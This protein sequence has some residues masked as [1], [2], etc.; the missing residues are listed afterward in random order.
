MIFQVPASV[1]GLPLRGTHVYS[2]Q[3]VP[4]FAPEA[5]TTS[6]FLIHVPKIS[7]FHASKKK[8]G[9]ISPPPIAHGMKPTC[10]IFNQSDG[11]KVLIPPG[12]CGRGVSDD[13]GRDASQREKIAPGHKYAHGCVDRERGG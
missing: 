1:E 6:P 7:G 3:W 8:K 5:A 10:G 13:D 4:I 2:S 9:G 11:L 12:Q